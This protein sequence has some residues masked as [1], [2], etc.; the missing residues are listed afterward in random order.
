MAELKWCRYCTRKLARRPYQLCIRC[1]LTQKIRQLF[2]PEFEHERL[3]QQSGSYSL[4]QAGLTIPSEPTDARP[5]TDEKIRVFSE[6]VDKG[7][8][9]FHPDDF[10]TLPVRFEEYS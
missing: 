6:R 5:G 1:Y 7:E 10:T 4:P 2:E 3:V 9:L 8:H